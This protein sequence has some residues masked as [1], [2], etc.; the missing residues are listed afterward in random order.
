MTCT[1]GFSP[2]SVLGFDGEGRL[3]DE[4]LSWAGVMRS[5]LT[6][7]LWGIKVVNGNLCIGVD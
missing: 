1:S 4:G 5:I 6:C 7:C 2:H 3:D